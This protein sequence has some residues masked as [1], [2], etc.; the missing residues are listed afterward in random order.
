MPD[1]AAIGTVRQYEVADTRQSLC[2]EV[3]R[4]AALLVPLVE[5]RELPE[6]HGGLDRVEARG[7][8]HRTVL[9]LPTLTML[10]Q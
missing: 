3:G 5:V 2:I 6:K 10:A 7:P 4:A 8:T 9:V 1:L